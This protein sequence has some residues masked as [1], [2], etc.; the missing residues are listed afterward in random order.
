MTEEYWRRWKAENDREVL[1]VNEFW[2][3]VQA[4]VQAHHPGGKH[5]LELDAICRADNPFIRQL[6]HSPNISPD[7]VAELI[8]RGIG[9]DLQFCMMLK[10]EGGK[11]LPPG[12]DCARE[13]GLFSRCLVREK[14]RLLAREEGLREAVAGGA[15]PVA[16][17]RERPT[18]QP[19][20]ET[21][22]HAAPPF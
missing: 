20:R 17:Q 19:V 6:K 22:L 21:P 8:C 10:N 5:Y 11:G 13:Y 4:D 12:A 2:R 1:Q 7:T 9:C 18:V 3:K 16:P 15:Q 14:Q